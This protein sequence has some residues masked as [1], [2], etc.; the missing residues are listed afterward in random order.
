M[1]H[2]INDLRQRQAA[3][4]NQPPQPIAQARA[5]YAPVGH[6]VPLPSD[7]TVTTVSANGVLA[8]WLDTPGIQPDSVL[9]FVHGGGYSLGSLRS[10]GPLAA[11]LGRELKLRVLF[12]EYGLAP[13]QPFPTAVND[14]L[15]AWRWLTTQGV[16]PVSVLV[17]GDSAG[18]GL[19]LG[20]LQ[21]LH[22]SQET[23]AGAVLISP[24]VDLTCSGASMVD[25]AEQ[26]PVFSQA[27]MQALAAQYLN[28]ADPH[29]PAASP[30]F[31]AHTGLPPLLIQVGGAE[32]LFSDSERLA[33]AA[34]DAGVEVTLQVADNLPH[35]YHGAL[36]TPETAAAV[37]QIV[38]WA[39]DLS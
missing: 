31:A 8:H 2:I 21:T 12:I 9:F 18:G 15:T 11:R 17:A 24:W 32:I 39:R 28:G 13:E 16:D 36:E 22:I 35:V 29:D 37:Q 6:L 20:L 25:R 19:V 34:A 38:D 4:I 7:V 23:P 30:L 33:K 26:D 10:H 14:V 27:R 5:A 3:R 1:Q